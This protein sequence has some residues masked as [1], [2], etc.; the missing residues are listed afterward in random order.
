MQ[1]IERRRIAPRDVHIVARLEVDR[2][3]AVRARA[4]Q[5]GAFG[6]VIN[7]PVGVS[8]HRAGDDDAAPPGV[9]CTSTSES[10][11]SPNASATTR[12]ATATSNE[13]AQLGAKT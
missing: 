12:N 10:K 6:D 8:K 7:V 3:E 4:K 1:L 13:A 2:P 11:P 5:V 9:R